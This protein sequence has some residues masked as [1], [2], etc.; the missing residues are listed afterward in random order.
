[1]LIFIV[2]IFVDYVVTIWCKY[3]HNILIVSENLIKQF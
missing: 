3:K 1:M 2:G